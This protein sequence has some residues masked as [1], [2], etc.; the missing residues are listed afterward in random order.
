MKALK[1]TLGLF[2]ALTI[3]APA[4]AETTLVYGSPA[5]P[6]GPE[7]LAVKAYFERVSEATNGSIQ[8]DQKYSGS[9]VSWGTSSLTGLRDNLVDGVFLTPAFTPSETPAAFVFI[10]LASSPGDLWVRTAASAETLLLNCPQCEAEWKKYNMRALTMTGSDPFNLM[11]TSEINSLAAMKDK[12]VRAAG[13]FANLGEAL[14]GT[15]VSVVPSELFEALQ[16]GQVNCAIGGVGWL[17]Q[18]GLGDVITHVVDSPLGYDQARLIM[19]LNED[20]W[21]GLSDEERAAFI[22]NLA[23]LHAEANQANTD[24]AESAKT[25]A[26]E[27]GVTFL[28]ISGE[29]LE[30]SDAHRAEVWDAVVAGATK[31]GV[32]DAQT[33]VDSYRSSYEKWEGIIA[34]IGY[35]RAAYEEALQREIYSKLK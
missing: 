35:D 18:F 15:A 3:A 8:F 9:V 17:R 24:Y 21:R 2:A 33:L 30:A 27:K 20:V 4:A 10:L 11:C 28:E 7:G 25:E 16:R 23:F 1:L 13:P 19:S 5:P 22:D 29:L 6:D 32:P 31:F 34:D 12:A 14:G 26:K